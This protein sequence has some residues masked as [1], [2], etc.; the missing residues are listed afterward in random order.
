LAADFDKI[1]KTDWKMSREPTGQE[2]VKKA[3]DLCES[4][5]RGFP[6]VTKIE[7]QLLAVMGKQSAAG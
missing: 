2:F 7:N 1:A 5:F 4:D 6:G 3:R